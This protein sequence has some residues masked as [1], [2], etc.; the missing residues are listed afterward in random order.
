MAKDKI[1]VIVG[2]MPDLI[3][4]WMEIAIEYEYL[5]I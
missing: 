4:R 2:E 3:A 5:K 1:T